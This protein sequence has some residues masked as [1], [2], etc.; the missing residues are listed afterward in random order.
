MGFNISKIT[1]LAYSLKI[2]YEKDVLSD[3]V[4][5]LYENN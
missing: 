3:R 4:V 2:N 1:T 5:I